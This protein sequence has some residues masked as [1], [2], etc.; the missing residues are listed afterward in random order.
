MPAWRCRPRSVARP[1]RARRA[2]ALIAVT[3]A[4]RVVS[5]RRDRLGRSGL[6]FA[7]AGCRFAHVAQALRA[8]FFPGNSSVLHVVGLPDHPRKVF[9][10]RRDRARVAERARL[11]AHAA[12]L[13]TSFARAASRRR[14]RCSARG[15]TAR[16]CSIARWSFHIFQCL[17]SLG[18]RHAVGG[19]PCRRRR[20]WTTVPAGLLFDLKW[21]SGLAPMPR[22]MKE[23]I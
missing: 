16:A 4:L 22:E 15:F 13:D 14:R 2:C 19:G 17:Q 21:R 5:V 11:R 6:L 1:R 10:V 8:L 3:A 20:C 12:A 23:R 9:R 7:S 18:G